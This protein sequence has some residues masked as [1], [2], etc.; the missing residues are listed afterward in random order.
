MEVDVFGV[1]ILLLER[2]LEAR[3]LSQSPQSDEDG[4]EDGGEVHGMIGKR[5]GMHPECHH[6]DDKRNVETERPTPVHPQR[7]AGFY[8]HNGVHGQREQV[9]ARRILFLKTRTVVGV[10][11]EYE[12]LHILRH[13]GEHKHTHVY[14]QTAAMSVEE[15]TCHYKM[16]HYVCAI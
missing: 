8:E 1:G 10:A 11:D 5:H 9:D 2:T 12:V 3:Q 6:Q 15:H 13:N 7:T 14:L 4:A 16:E